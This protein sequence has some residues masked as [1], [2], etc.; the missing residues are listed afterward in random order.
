[1]TPEV[2]ASKSL[3]EKNLDICQRFEAWAKSGF[4]ADN[5]FFGWNVSTKINLINPN[6][7]KFMHVHCAPKDLDEKVLWDRK[8]NSRSYSEQ[9]NRKSDI[10]LYYAVKDNYLS[11]TCGR[12]SSS[13]EASIR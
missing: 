3:K 13:N 9:R 7:T 12:Y 5:E 6:F 10:V 11:F 2:L 1:M 8:R 4:K